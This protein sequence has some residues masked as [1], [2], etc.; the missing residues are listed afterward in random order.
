MW[1]IELNFFLLFFSRLVFTLLLARSYDESEKRY[2]IKLFLLLSWKK[3]LKKKIIF[4]IE[5]KK[6]CTLYRI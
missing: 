4:E 3:K 6:N 1:K 2:F 5:I